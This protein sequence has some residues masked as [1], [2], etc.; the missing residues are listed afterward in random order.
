M[1]LKT[2]Y[3][4]GPGYARL[5]PAVQWMAGARPATAERQGHRSLRFLSEAASG[6]PEQAP[7]REDLAKQPHDQR[8]ALKQKRQGYHYDWNQDML[9]DVAGSEAVTV[10]I[11]VDAGGKL[12]FAECCRSTTRFVGGEEQK[13]LQAAAERRV[14]IPE[15]GA[16]L[17]RG[18][19]WHAG[20]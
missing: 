11:T 6:A 3:H 16:C 7:S 18:N 8:H 2:L 14:R 19:M 9:R 5:R 10:V 4:L 13:V 15:R 12:L 17:F 20:D 1:S